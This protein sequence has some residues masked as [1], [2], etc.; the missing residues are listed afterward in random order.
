MKITGRVELVAVTDVLCDV[1]QCSTR[2]RSD[3][4]QFATLRAHWGYDSTHDGE[5]YELHLC[6]DC[7]LQTVAYLKLERRTQYL[8]NEDIHTA[9]I[10]GSLGLDIKDDYFGAPAIN[11]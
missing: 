9:R 8:F 10:D 6:E 2:V 7:I 5:R 4:R 11:R 3:G 1:C